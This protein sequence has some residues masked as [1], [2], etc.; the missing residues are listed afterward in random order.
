MEFEDYL[1]NLRTKLR[2]NQ[3]TDFWIMCDRKDFNPIKGLSEAKLEQQMKEKSQYYVG[4]RI[5][6][7]RI[8]VDPSKKTIENDEMVIR[9]AIVVMHINDDAELDTSKS[10]HLTVNYYIEELEERKFK[11]KDVERMM[12]LCASKKVKSDPLNGITFSEVIKKLKKKNIN[13]DD[14]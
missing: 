13:L 7:I 1:I 9:V 5:A 4:K 6:N 8:Y 14:I 12:R 10:R 11:L 3:L 2:D